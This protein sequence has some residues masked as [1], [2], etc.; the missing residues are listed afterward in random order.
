MSQN[1]FHIS[2]RV[3]DHETHRAVPGLRVEAWDKDL[4]CDDLVGSAITDEQGNFHIEFTHTYF[5]ELFLDRRPDLFFKVFNQNNNLIA[6]TEDSIL[7][8]VEAAETPIEIAV[9]LPI[10]ATEPERFV[11]KGQI[12]G[13][14]G[15]PLTSVFV[16]TF[17]RDLRQEQALGSRKT[18]SQDG[19]YAITY[20][21]AQFCRAEKG[22]ADLIVRVY[23]A[24]DL[25]IAESPIIFNAK[26][27]EIVN[28]QVA[29][30]A[31][32]P[33]SEYENLIAALSPLLEEVPLADLTEADIT[34]LSGDTGIAPQRIR[35]L[36]QTARL[37]LSTELPAEI[38]Y[39]LA[40][41]NLPL[42]LPELLT[43]SPITLRQALETA[44][45][46]NLIPVHLQSELDNTLQR[47]Q[48]LAIAHSL[49]DHPD[50]NRV[51]LGKLLNTSL[52]PIPDEQRQA[53]ARAYLQHQGSIS[54]FWKEL[55][56]KPE[57]QQQESLI[58]D[59]QFTVQ[60][61]NLTQNYLPLVRALQSLRQTGTLRSPRDLAQLNLSAWTN[62]IQQHG[63]PPDTPG[64]DPTEKAQNYAQTIAQ[65]I[66]AAFP[67]AVV[68]YRIQQTNQ[69]EETDLVNFFSN[70]LQHPNLPEFDFA[71]T[72]IDR[73]L[74]D[75]GDTVLAG[76]SDRTHFTQQLKTWQRLFKITPHYSTMRMLL[77]DG[78]HS[79]QSI[80]Q[81][82]PSAFLQRYRD[83]LGGQTATEQL[84]DQAEQISG[85]ALT[86]ITKYGAAF[87]GVSPSV[88]PSPPSPSPA[89]IKEIP[90]CQTLFG[91]LDFC[92][93]EHCRSVYSPAAYLVDVLTFLKRSAN[94]QGKTA[95]AILFE[96]RP[97]LGNIE[98]SCA[99]TNTPVPYIDLVNEI[100]ENVVAPPPSG[101]PQPQTTGTSEELSTNPEYINAEAYNIL[102]QQVYPWNLPFDRWAVESQ[103]YLENL[104]AQRDQLLEAAYPIAEPTA[105]T[106]VAILTDPTITRAYLGM[107]T[108]EW[109]IV[110]GTAGNHP[111][112]EFWG[113]PATSTPPTNWVEVVSHVSTFLQ[114]SQLN[115]QELCELLAT[116][117]ITP[118]PAHPM[119]WIQP[120]ETC[121]IDQMQLSPLANLTP[122]RLNNVQCFV[123]LQR[124]LGWT[125]RELDQA[126]T[127]F[128]PKD[129][130]GHP[131]VT[132][133]FL[134]QLSHL[135]RLRQSL[136]LPL[137]KLLSL[138][139]EI[140]TAE[141]R[142]V[143]MP[144]SA[145]LYAQLFQNKTIFNS[146]AELQA[147]AV[148]HLGT[149]LL[150]QHRSTLL[151][152]LSIR[153]ADLTALEEATHLDASSPLTL[154]NLSILYR[155]TLLAKTLK[156]SIPDFLAVKALIGLNPFDATHTE[157][158]VL[159]LEKVKQIRASGFTIAQ[160]N[161]LY[162]YSNYAFQLKPTSTSAPAPAFSTVNVLAKTLLNGLNQIIDG[163]T[164]TVISA[165]L[166]QR[167]LATILNDQLASAAIAFLNRIPTDISNNTPTNTLENRTL[168][169]L[170]FGQFLP[171]N[172][173]TYTTLLIVTLPN[174]EIE[175]IP[176]ND[177]EVRYHNGV[178]A[179]ET[180]IAQFYQARSIAYLLEH[181]LPYLRN[182]LSHALVKQTLSHALKLDKDITEQLLEQILKSRRNPGEPAI[183]D[184]LALVDAG[185][186][187]EY[188]NTADLTGTPVHRIDPTL[189]FSW[190]TVPPM[191]AITAHFFSV[192]WTGFLRPQSSGEAY[193]LHLRSNSGI[194]LWVDDELLLDQ[195]AN[196]ELNEFSSAVPHSLDPMGMSMVKV[197]YTN[198]AKTAIVQLSWSSPSTPKAIVPQSQLN[199]STPP[200]YS[201]SYHSYH[202]FTW[203]YNQL[204]KVA[205]LINGL[206]LTV[207][208]VNYLANH[209]EDFA[210]INPTEP[211]NQNKFVPLDF[212]ALARVGNEAMPAFFNQWERLY[213]FVTLRKSLPPTEEVSLI[214]VFA[215]S[216]IEATQK[217]AIATGWDTAELDVLSAKPTLKF[218]AKGMPVIELQYRLNAAGA[219][220]VL[221]VN[222][223]FG[224]LTRQAV[225]TFQQ[226]HH[227]TADGVVGPKTWRV[228]TLNDFKQERHLVRLQACFTLC[229]KLGIT[230]R[231]F[232]EWSQH[233]P[234]S[235]QAQAIK[236]VL[237]ARYEEEDEWLGAAKSL[238]DNLREQQRS[239][240]V[241]YLLS[242]PQRLGLASL[243]DTDVLYDYLLIDVEM[244][245]CQMTSRI[246]QAISSVQLFVQRCLM[247]LELQAAL[248]EYLAKEWQWMKHYRVWEANRKIF[249]YPEN[250][251][252]PALRDDKSP[253]FKD[254]ENELLQ[255]EMTLDT[256]ETAFRNYLEKLDAVAN[257]AICGMYYQIGVSAVGK[258][259]TTAEGK[260]ETNILHVFGR[261]KGGK[262]YTYYYR[263]RVDFTHWTP[264]E[265]VDLDIQSEHLIPV[266]YERR[267]RLFWPL[268]TEK[269]EAP[270]QYWA[271]QMA[272]SEYK[273]GKWSSKKVSPEAIVTQRK[274]DPSQYTF[275][276]HTLLQ[277]RLQFSMVLSKTLVIF[278]FEQP[279]PIETDT[280]APEFPNIKYPNADTM[281][282]CFQFVGCHE[283]IY[284]LSLF[285][286]FTGQSFP[287]HQE[288]ASLILW[289]EI[290]RCL[291]KPPVGA[292][293]QGMHFVEGTDDRLAFQ[294]Y[295]T[296]LLNNYDYTLGQTPGQFKVLFPAQYGLLEFSL[297]SFIGEQNQKSYNS[298]PPRQAF[299]PFFYQDETRTFFV[300]L[301][302][303]PRPKAVT[304][305]GLNYN[306][307]PPNF[308]LKYRFEEFYHPYICDFI[309][310]LNRYGID[311]LLKPVEEQ[312][313][314]TLDQSSLRRQLCMNEYFN[315]QYHPNPSVVAKP[316]PFAHIDFFSTGSYSLYNWELFFHIPLL[317]ADR[318]M[319]NQRFEDAQKWFHYIFD[320]TIGVNL[321]LDQELVEQR[322]FF[323]YI[324]QCL[325]LPEAG[326]AV[327][328]RFWQVQP[329]FVNMYAKI[330]IQQ[331]L[332]ILADVDNA[333]PIRTW[334][335]AMLEAEVRQWR[336]DPFKPHLIAR[337][338]IT[339]YQKNVVMK[340]L[341]NLIA[342][343][344][345]LFRRETLESINEATQLYILAAKIL[346]S[347][348]TEVH[349]QRP[350]PAQTYN[351]LE[352][353]LDAF[354]NAL[355]LL[356]NR[357]PVPQKQ[358]SIALH[359]PDLDIPRPWFSL[360]TTLYFCIPKND[361]L[362]R[363][364]DLVGDRLFK[365]RHCMNIEGVVRQLPLFEPPINPALLV[366]AAAA[367]LDLGSV[368]NDLNAPLPHYR[369]TVMLQ[370]A[371]ELCND[372]K[373]LGSELLSALEKRDAEALAILRSSQEIKLL[374]A[375]RETKNKQI[376]EAKAFREG[377]N[378][379]KA[380]I[381]I[382][383][384]YYQNLK[385]F[386]DAESTHLVLMAA[387]A[388]AQIVAQGLEVSAS[389][390]YVAPDEYVGAMAGTG[391]GPIK[392]MKVA[393]GSST[394]SSL[395]AASGEAGMIAAMLNL[396]AT[397]T[398][399]MGSYDRRWEEWKHQENLANKELEQ[400]D[401]QIAA[402]DIRVAIAEQDL[403]THDL[404]MENAETVDTYMHDKFTNR[405]LYDWMVGQISAI[406][407]QSYQLA[408]DIA[409]RAERTYRFELGL[410]DSDFIQFGYWDSLRK[411]LLAGEKLHYDLK[412]METAYL[413]HHKRE[414]EITKHIS[415]VMLD[416]LALIKLKETGQ[417]FVDLPE[418]LFD[419]D[420]PGHYMRRI[421]SIS[422]TIPCVT[423]PYTSV[424]CTLTLLKNSLRKTSIT[425]QPYPRKQTEQ[426][427]P[428]E[429]DRFIDT[430][431]VIQSIVTS[432]AQNDS[433]L[434]E[435][436]F[437]D[438]RYLPFEGAGAI[439]T[440][441]VELPKACNRFDFNTIADAILHLK[442]TA[443][444]GGELLK[445][446][447]L[448]AREKELNRLIEK[449]MIQVQW[450]SSKHH[451]P[452][453][454]HQFLQ[455][456]KPQVLSLNLAL[457]Q[458][459]FQHA[460]QTIMIQQIDIFLK[461]KQD[462]ALNL[463]VTITPPGEPATPH[464][465]K[466]KK[467]SYGLLLASLS[468]SDNEYLA[469]AGKSPCI[470][471]LEPKEVT[472][473]NNQDTYTPHVLTPDDV[474]D[475]FFICHYFVSKQE[476]Q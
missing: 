167:Q 213:A 446:A 30:E 352:P 413:E 204:H 165:D 442:Y 416:P 332:E 138:W 192:R 320:P 336:K 107:T 427:Y 465:E 355:V 122:Q 157:N 227:L 86:L 244:S 88:I 77:V 40:R 160:L 418:A 53:F 22:N 417:C 60:L 259:E 48:E 62:L 121:Q 404:Q 130:N 476:P 460:P 215:A 370:K 148:T 437:H 61:G 245:A 26:P 202:Y 457:E 226:T 100:L 348:P 357:L 399:T 54:D 101:T 433:G 176:K 231:Q 402:A 37:T 426:E 376:Q 279:Q 39:G 392:L 127:A 113:Y 435:L 16:R 275:L 189:N 278:C 149:D 155:Y 274:L 384:N 350:V 306:R 52:I 75:H 287:L 283:T 281:V 131:A 453:Q 326:D 456:K 58:N 299:T 255:G 267:L 29:G 314:R 353:Q 234:N 344:D 380:V 216:G 200:F 111:I 225:I 152:V 464:N 82:G 169:Q 67:T 361:E 190:G 261:T 400:L 368:L 64:N 276:S 133:T 139:A 72:Q 97:D 150:A 140:D 264:W 454:W 232:L 211:A 102:L 191:P 171:L 50:L 175:L 120:L 69:P 429:D 106:R 316:Y 235:L 174:S 51:S 185:L 403:K 44:L 313:I 109:Q 23:R 80:V 136:K 230:T 394:G 452:N 455:S 108:L 110:T 447:A 145:S 303:T 345:Q 265:K 337:M 268:F 317:I 351:E 331:L 308:E 393:G 1:T 363:Y 198:N 390:A 260:P 104:G 301:Q 290:Y 443:R 318:L 79:A 258:I 74:D 83:R 409:K 391:G 94:P 297:N 309:Q 425:S 46:E 338:R 241:A 321:K 289:Y 354:S 161:Y 180:A 371:I 12:R 300:A 398:A 463:G 147:F 49:E 346:G 223:S 219:Q 385:Y 115:Y 70:Y 45:R 154:A 364:W 68:I 328:N 292:A 448:N 85:M 246:K 310:Q 240:L 41:Q 459:P 194:K 98:L 369:F 271:I 8:N 233:E 4:I 3:I 356:E 365:I 187:G 372:I 269:G 42:T 132:A 340:Y 388:E 129:G 99:N 243:K 293:Y 71:A 112:S 27:V 184:F 381:E 458:F 17:D 395:R 420:Y 378:L 247:G 237:K 296:L 55:S 451:F 103:V 196:A 319:Q 397:M 210:G 439:S 95:K 272:W 431:G 220:P 343:G 87:N 195:W 186:T 311:G 84:F 329:F 436:N 123:R 179:K 116:R 209:G 401:R 9:D 31:V 257:L 295:S 406:Y 137:V 251:I 473:K 114:R 288:P 163:T 280:G 273:H 412:R 366:K 242:H 305:F 325:G 90:D 92:T 217:L 407:F 117:W 389:T 93:C 347:R 249:L 415:L 13:A 358:V 59:L 312:S 423:G 156:L 475:I 469:E 224:T 141:Y 405:E 334:L 414:Y 144:N 11:V 89:A 471:L 360:L 182:I 199:V 263:C 422:L 315:N 253:F 126:I 411:G 333:D 73:Y 470:W 387:A 78:I 322:K 461:P 252:E 419:L 205:L 96:R 35:Y 47:L 424:N 28:L 341:D 128:Q 474:E 335:R 20:T 359:T 38:L 170:Y 228:L 377:L 24:G 307:T 374:E 173:D 432:S 197:E 440:W 410:E 125:I 386:N 7:W 444:E 472:K 57:F 10:I 430:F 142:I 467:T 166:L 450:L 203:S 445:Q 383:R 449:G 382:R 286:P 428:A 327:L 91:S 396:M 172:P 468:A 65:T 222:G 294:D 21:R 124:Q 214:D 282:G 81:L 438:D 298:L 153:D 250:W 177:T 256:A 19:H 32:P 146:E 168:I 291:F 66:E 285:Q 462:L 118:D 178:I 119:L 151:A 164:V 254:L 284:Y 134:I 262:P 302:I 362:L 434:F 5:Q 56:Q 221:K 34:F 43:Q 323:N 379:T 375:I 6:S 421:K 339:P 212:N 36:V 105:L 248:D 466:C 158:T 239:A 188:F 76:V 201:Y 441:R 229:E 15:N 324:L 304:A 270:N 159:I 207:K 2:G 218:H 342:W 367:G 162:T 373:A 238:K 14:D 33:L 208:E 193:T 408:Y 183:A 206:K 63:F 143:G 277:P 236:S 181:L 18:T 330:S 135:Q 25:V 349:P 266:V